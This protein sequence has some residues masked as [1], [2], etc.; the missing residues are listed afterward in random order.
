MT[1]RR[2]RLALT[3]TVLA[4]ALLAALWP[5]KEDPQVQAHL[6]ALADE[7]TGFARAEGPQPLSF[8]ADHGPH[9]DYQTEWWYYTGNLETSDGRHFGYQLTFFR[10]AL[11]PPAQRQ[12]R[13]SP[14]AA[15]QVYLA[16]F[17]L[18]DVAG[19]RHHAFDR[20]SRG[21]AGL[22]GAQTAPYQVWLEDWSVEELEPGVYHLSAAQDDL[23]ID[24]R[25]TDV[26]G[27]I[28]QGDRGYS[29]KG[30]EPGNASY[31]YSLTR[32]ASSGTV[33]VGE[34]SY[35]VD[36]LSWMDHEFS[37]GALGPD[38]VGWDWFSIQLGD[39]SELMVYQ[40]RRE[41]GTA[42]P[43]STGTCV[44]AA[45]NTTRL[46]LQ[47]VA[48][49]VNDTWRSPHSGATY[50]AQWTV[51]VPSEGLILEVTPYL[52]DQELDAS[53]V[54]WEGAVKIVGEHAG[55]AVS[56]NGYVE[57]TGYAQSMQGQL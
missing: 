54:Y 21:A 26:K 38:L 5:R 56:G 45:G 46:G 12:D 36:G 33:R 50:P 47:D 42:D 11:L 40:L 31:Y 19:E 35:R 17:A 9:P 57:L 16:H 48:V 44:D 41:D 20:F 13:V 27:P 29:Q 24:L 1:F 52:A 15:D 39:G 55:N 37:T 2:T 4:M 34:T 7:A 28:L 53:F 8:P 25:L 51:T 49:E 6:V 3:L 22:A 14:W 43:F 30:P 32:L 18:A 10:R 23:T